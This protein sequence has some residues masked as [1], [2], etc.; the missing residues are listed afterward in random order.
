MYF[1]DCE[2]PSDLP[3]A[4][5]K[6]M[7]IQTGRRV[8]LSGPGSGAV[9]LVDERTDQ[10][11]RQGAGEVC[12]VARKMRKTWPFLP[13]V[14]EPDVLPLQTL[15]M[16]SAW[17]E[18]ASANMPREAAETGRDIGPGKWERAKAWFKTHPHIYGLAGGG[19]LLIVFLVLGL[20]IP[21][22]RSWCLGTAAISLVVL[23]LSVLGGRTHA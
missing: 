7:K 18:Q 11:L 20:L 19:V 21:E 3:R 1:N 4:I 13:D 9:A 8:T 5:S 16:L 15:A 2:R 14:P 17:A 12:A 10:T 6:F 22:W 23:I